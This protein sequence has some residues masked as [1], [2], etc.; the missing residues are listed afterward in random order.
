MPGAP[1]PAP[2]IHQAHY[3][4]TLENVLEGPGDDASLAGRVRQA[5]HG[6]GLPAARLAVGKDGAVVAL[7]DALRGG[8]PPGAQLAQ[9]ARAQGY[10]LTQGRAHRP[11]PA[12]FSHH[13]GAGWGGPCRDGGGSTGGVGDRPC[14][15]LR[16]WCHPL[17][18]VP[19]ACSHPG[20]RGLGVLTGAKGSE[21]HREVGLLLLRRSVVSDFPTPWTTARQ[22]LLYMIL[23]ARVLE[24]VAIYFS[25][26]SS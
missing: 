8:T 7:S 3:L 14:V 19:L 22:A 23:Q 13:G 18:P 15:W 12:Q 26:G 5:L 2:A 16:A 6:E 10:L 9:H 4:D 25:R 1:S 21:Q 20:A 11:P 24:W 17:L